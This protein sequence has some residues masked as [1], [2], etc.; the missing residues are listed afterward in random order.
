M[1]RGEDGKLEAKG[2]KSKNSLIPEGLTVELLERNTS[3]LIKDYHTER[4]SLYL[5]KGIKRVIKYVLTKQK[6]R[7]IL[8]TAEISPKNLG[9][10]RI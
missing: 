3:V 9:S 7:K 6:D 10:P 5:T 1:G 4:L 8:N 2:W